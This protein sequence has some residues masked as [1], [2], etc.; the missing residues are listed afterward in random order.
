MVHYDELTWFQVTDPE[1][2]DLPEWIARSAIDPSGRVFLPADMFADEAK[3]ALMTKQYGA[4]CVEVEEHLYLA[5]DWFLEHFP[6]KEEVIEA[7][8]RAIETAAARK[9]QP[10]H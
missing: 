10:L 4:D 2:S 3:V 5:S 1:N 6:E 9:Q 8:V 7:A